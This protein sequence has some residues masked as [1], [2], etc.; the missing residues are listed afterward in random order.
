M[1]T[2]IGALV[3]CILLLTGVAQAATINFS[4]PLRIIETDEG[5]AIYSGVPV[6]T[7]FSGSIDDVT[8][9]GSITG[10][11]ITTSFGCCIAAGGL[12]FTDDLT[13]DASFAALLNSLSGSTD[14]AAGQ[15]YDLADLEGDSE[16]APDGRIEVGLSFLFPADTYDNDDPTNVLDPAA[17]LLTAFF[18]FE[19]A[20]DDIYSGIG[21]AVV[22][23]PGA[24][25]L[26]CSA[27]GY[28]AWRRR[29]AG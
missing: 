23:L 27:L 4:G 13:L 10:A 26:L 15:L 21:L 5:G 6:G 9:N 11:G 8:A 12:E 17:A 14:F 25:W 1:K 18:I 3:P 28:L 29:Q 24:L 20:G 2:L 7:R 16:V 22:P 19:E